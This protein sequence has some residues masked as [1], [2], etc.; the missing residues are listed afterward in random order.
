MK[1]AIEILQQLIATPSLSG[2]E[3]D[4]AEILATELSERGVEVC[5]LHNNVWALS[6]GYDASK[7]TLMLNSHQDT[8]KPSAA[9]T[10]NP[11]EPTIEDDKLYGLGSN[12]AGASLVALLTAFCNNYDTSDA[13]Y[14][15]LLALTAEEENM[16]ERGMRAFLPHLAEQGV[17][18]DMVLVGEP[19]SMQ[20]ATAERGLVVLDCTAHGKSGHAARNEGENA[21][22][23]AMC[24]IEKLCN[25]RF[26]RTSEQLG[27]IKITVTQIS[28][29]TQHNIVPDECR[30]V[31]DVRTTDAY[32]NEEVVEILQSVVECDA[33][34]RSTRVRASAISLSHPLVQAA[35]AIGRTT[36]VSPT[37][38]DRAIMQG[39]PALKMGVGE[40]SRSHTADEFVLVSEVEEGVAIY[41]QLLDE[42]K[43]RL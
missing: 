31:A 29:G 41:Q 17:K 38:S 16:G 33:K 37:T 2:N 34:P 43:N 13:P 18:V 25:Y 27:D 42:L 9:Y 10:R 35:T 5:R 1:R 4:T 8:V 19:T 6:K 36:F 20:A 40:S 3:A 28:A 14:N 12:D 7:P 26:E 39:L 30:F 15:L 22:Y 32:S 24:D 21:I 11:F 23:K